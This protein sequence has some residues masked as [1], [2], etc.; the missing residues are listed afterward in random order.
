MEFS[1]NPIRVELF[2]L[3]LQPLHLQQVGLLPIDLLVQLL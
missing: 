3:D 1:A 2:I